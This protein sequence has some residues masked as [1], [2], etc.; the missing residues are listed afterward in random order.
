MKKLA[1]T[2]ISA[3]LVILPSVSHAFKRTTIESILVQACK[4]V[5]RNNVVRLKSN[6]KQNYLSVSLIN[7]KLMCNGESVYDFALTH[8]ADKTARA[9]RM[10]S[11]SIRDI[12]YKTQIK[13]QVWLD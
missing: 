8:N 2:I 10:G 9:L 11:V 1:L 6:L 12:A 13:Y 5:K 4:D 7:E 3:S